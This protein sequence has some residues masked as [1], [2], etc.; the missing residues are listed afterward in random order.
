M[1]NASARN[2]I[3]VHRNKTTELDMID[4]I[5]DY[6]EDVQHLWTYLISC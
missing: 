3:A 1:L 6:M 4:V 5:S 2:N